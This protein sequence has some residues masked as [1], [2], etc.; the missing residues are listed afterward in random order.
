M[1]PAAIISGSIVQKTGYYNPF[2]ILT[3]VIMPIGA[4]LL[5]TFTPTTGHAKWIAYQF[6]FGFGMGLG[7]QQPNLAAQ[8]T[9]AKRQVPTAISVIMFFQTLGGAVFSSVAQNLLSSKL[10]K[11]L[12]NIPGFDSSNVVTIG[13]TE[14]RNV[15]PS[16]YVTQVID[17]YNLAIKDVFYLGVALASCTIFGA[18]TI[19]WKNLKRSANVTQKAPVAG[20]KEAAP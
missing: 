10:V 19:E 6:L 4:G 17:V 11:G 1:V 13:A 20:E 2:M 9:V 5:C 18:L 12:A 8:A 14:L 15:I 16:Q 7:M 3:A